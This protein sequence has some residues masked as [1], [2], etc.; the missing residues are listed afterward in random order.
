MK[1]L[2]R[3]LSAL[4]LVLGVL[5]LPSI[6]QASPSPSSSKPIQANEWTVSVDG[7]VA[8]VRPGAVTAQFTAGVC[9]GTF[10]S[11]RQS[12]NSVETSVY[13]Q[14]TTPYV[15]SA[16][17][18]IDKCVRNG[19]PDDFKCTTVKRSHGSTSGKAYQLT[20][21][22]NTSSCISGQYRPRAYYQMVNGVDVPDVNGNV[23]TVTCK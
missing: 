19:G 7:T 13:Y 15:M 14:C 16:S 5:S 8:P 2:L 11:P 21:P 17:V 12:N 18:A 4:A 22:V 23:V 6:A 20:V 10:T 3:I 1:R 9:R